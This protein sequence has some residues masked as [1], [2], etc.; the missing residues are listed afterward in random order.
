MSADIY[1]EIDSRPPEEEKKKGP[2][3]MN[4]EM[5]QAKKAFDERE[6]R[7]KTQP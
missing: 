5:T 1:T 2:L 6:E 7:K 4:L 3:F